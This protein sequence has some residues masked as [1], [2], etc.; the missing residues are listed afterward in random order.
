M[1]ETHT[2]DAVN[3]AGSGRNPVGWFEI[4]VA[5]MQRAKDFYGD[6][7]QATFTESPMSGGDMEMWFFAGDPMAAG[8]SGGLIRHDMRQ[9]GME[10]TLVYF[11]VDDCAAAIARATAR[12]S[13]VLVDR[14][15]IGEMGFIG[16]VTDNEGNS[17]GLHSMM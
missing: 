12:G 13:T 3:I 16:I 5:N 6:V 2:P 17:I 8:A 15:S 11:S 1:A 14:L 7:V 10:G 4:Y 9:P